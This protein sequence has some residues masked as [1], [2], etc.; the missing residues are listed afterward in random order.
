M[1]K[2]ERERAFLKAM[3]F[4]LQ[5]CNMR[6]LKCPC[7]CTNV[8]LKTWEQNIIMCICVKVSVWVCSIKSFDILGFDLFYPCDVKM[9]VCVLNVVWCNVNLWFWNISFFLFSLNISVSLLVSFTLYFIR[10]FQLFQF[11]ILIAFLSAFKTNISLFSKI[12][13]RFKGW[14]FV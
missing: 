4:T 11:F 12:T 5:I 3:S 9:H 2:G 13:L 8:R 7:P 6:M 14:I 10:L 1:S